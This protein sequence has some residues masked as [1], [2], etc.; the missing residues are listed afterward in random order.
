MWQNEPRLF[1]VIALVSVS[2]LCVTI[3]YSIVITG[4]GSAS[5]NPG[6]ANNLQTKKALSRPYTRVSRCRDANQARIKRNQEKTANHHAKSPVSRRSMP[7]HKSSFKTQESQ[8]H[9]LSSRFKP[10]P[11][12]LTG[13]IRLFRDALSKQRQRELRDIDAP[14]PVHLH[15][16]RQ[17]AAI[18]TQRVDGD[19][20]D[21]YAFELEAPA[22]DDGYLH[23][24]ALL[25]AGIENHTFSQRNDEH[26]GRSSAAS[27]YL[28]IFDVLRHIKTQPQPTLS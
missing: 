22:H 26:L 8:F 12:N 21:L 25:Q 2:F 27:N 14:A 15:V 4:N 16:K 5:P 24:V 9:A 3:V 17:V 18:V 20:Q 11:Q 13:Q 10:H 19:L 6:P 1:Q 23:P 28:T 7:I